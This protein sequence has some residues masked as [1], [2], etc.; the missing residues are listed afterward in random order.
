MEGVFSKSI[1]IDMGERYKSGMAPMFRKEFIINKKI[2]RATVNIIGLG[3]YELYINGK[4]I[5]DHLLDPAQTDYEIRVFYNTFNVTEYVNEKNCIGVIL[6]DGWYHQYKIWRHPENGKTNQIYGKP[7]LIFEMIIEYEDGDIEILPSDLSWKTDYSPIVMN[8]IFTGEVYDAR[9]EQT[10]WNTHLYDESHWHKVSRAPDTTGEIEYQQI[11]PIKKMEYVEPVAVIPLTNGVYVFDMGTNFAGF[12]KIKAL[13]Y[14][15]MDIC[16]RYSESLNADG[17]L[18][19]SNYN[20]IVFHA[21]QEDRYIAG[22]DGVFEWEPRFTYHGFRYV[23]IT[24]FPYPLQLENITGIRVYT[25]LEEAGD[26]E[27]SEEVFNKMHMLAVNTIKSNIHSIPTDCPVR[28][29]GGWTGDAVT[30]CSTMNYNFKSDTFWQKYI[31]DIQSSRKLYGTWMNIVPGRRTCLDASTAWGSAQVLLPWENYVFYGDKTSLEK[32]YDNIKSWIHHLSEKS[33]DYILYDEAHDDWCTPYEIFK[34]KPTKN[35]ISTAYF[36]FS[37]FLAAKIAKELN[38]KEDAECFLELSRGIKAAF[39]EKFYITS[40]GGYGGQG[41]SAMAVCVGLAD[42][43]TIHKTVSYIVDDIIKNGYHLM[44][45]HI[46]AKYIF[47]VLYTYGY[48]DILLK[49]LRN[50]KYPGFLYMLENGATTL[51][52]RWEGIGDYEKAGGSLNHPFKCGYDAWFYKDILG[53]RPKNIGFDEI[54]IQPGMT[55][56]LKYAK[57]YYISNHGRI[58]VDWR[59]QEKTFCLKV[60]IPERTKAEIIMPNNDV[61]I[62][63]AGQHEFTQS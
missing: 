63:E 9:L 5:G 44:V 19:Y 6:G 41:V 27:C 53:I 39:H 7:K 62:V 33:D 21:I 50:P 16:I 22:K 32:S 51:W 59:M 56:Y 43:A 29:K 13:G 3:F 23:E 49:S 10:G 54:V 8:N 48:T 57:G 2:K 20:Q 24:G 42:Q 52:E 60:L 28:E 17:K 12:I 26:F 58:E 30:L 14:E 25:S 18:Q 1:W 36:Y 35:Q 37:T 38:I 15:G 46:G 40:I 55:D 61:K 31:D 45:G 47:E 4:R 34:N 11:E